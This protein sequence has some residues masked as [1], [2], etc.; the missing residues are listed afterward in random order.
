LFVSINEYEMLG[1]LG[2]CWFRILALFN[3]SL[4]KLLKKK[5][6]MMVTFLGGFFF[7]LCDDVMCDRTNPLLAIFF[8]SF[9]DLDDL[10]HGALA[11]LLLKARSTTQ[12]SALLLAATSVRNNIHFGRADGKNVTLKW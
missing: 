6:A 2:F 12:H 9:P 8:A 5:T 10:C 4:Q 7:P 1:G 11:A 3:K